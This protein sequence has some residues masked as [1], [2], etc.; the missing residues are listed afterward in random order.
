MGMYTWLYRIETVEYSK[1][2]DEELNKLFQD[3]RKIMYGVFISERVVETKMFLLGKK[4]ETFYNIYHLVGDEIN[5]ISEVR[6]LNLSLYSK[7]LTYNYLC[8]LYNGYNY[9]TSRNLPSL[10]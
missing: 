1:V 5:D 9:R 4:V 8:G 10:N 3:V 2:S 6:C 7:E